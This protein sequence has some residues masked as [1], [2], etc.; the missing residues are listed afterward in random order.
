MCVQVASVCLSVCL[1]LHHPSCSRLHARPVRIL[2]SR[3]ESEVAGELHQA[4]GHG[5]LVHHTGHCDDGDREA[6]T[7]RPP[8]NH[9]YVVPSCRRARKRAE[10]WKGDHGG[11]RQGLFIGIEATLLGGGALFFTS[12]TYAGGPHSSNGQPRLECLCRPRDDG[13]QQSSQ[14]A[15]EASRGGTRALGCGKALVGDHGIVKKW[16]I[17]IWSFSAH[18]TAP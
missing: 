5:Q 10:V 13:R 16:W 7:P 6:A 4:I 9:A 18:G 8:T 11:L 12:A 3:K 17:G 2:R 15:S 14:R 1:S